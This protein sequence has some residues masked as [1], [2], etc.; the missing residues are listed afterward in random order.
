MNS[1]TACKQNIKTY[2]NYKIL[3]DQNHFAM[4]RPISGNIKKKEKKNMS[5]FMHKPKFQV[6]FFL[7]HP[8]LT[9]S[10]IKILY[11]MR[12]CRV[13]FENFEISR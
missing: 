8:V 13:N 9:D 12:S 2:K 1:P 5:I 3:T 10:T 4:V 7:G 6:A 11:Y